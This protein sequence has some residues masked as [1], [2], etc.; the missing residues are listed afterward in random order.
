MEGTWDATAAN[1][2]GYMQL[3][4]V[5]DGAISIAADVK[6]G[7]V[8]GTREQMVLVSPRAAIVNGNIVST[9]GFATNDTNFTSPG[10]TT[11]A[12][13]AI[14]TGTHTAATQPTDL[15]F[16][17]TEAGGTATSTEKMRLTGRGFLGIGTTSPQYL[18]SVASSTDGNIFQLYDSDGNCLQNP[19][20]GAITTTCT[21]DE[22]LKE[23]IRNTE[24]TATEYF[25]DFRIRDYEVKSSGDTMTGV[26]AQE[27]RETHPELV[28]DIAP[29]ITEEIILPNGEATTTSRLGDTTE[30]VE[31]PSTWQLIKAIQELDARVTALEAEKKVVAADSTTKGAAGGAAVVLAGLGAWAISRRKE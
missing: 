4:A 24:L 30:F 26:I 5:V 16:F 1:Q 18:L 25:K 6:G 7:S 15:A 3:A 13:K 22:K 28:K 11:A 8:D 20:A 27:V 21:S 23:N 19:E 29:V 2:D 17:T 12:I 14:A 9:L 10:T 31:I